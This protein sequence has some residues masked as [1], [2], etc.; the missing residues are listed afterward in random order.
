MVD[1]L[2]LHELES[3]LQKIDLLKSKENFE[4]IILDNGLSNSSEDEVNEFLVVKFMSSEEVDL[5]K[6]YVTHK[7]REDLT[8]LVDAIDSLSELTARIV[9]LY[10]EINRCKSIINSINRTIE[11]V[12]FSLRDYPNIRV[13]TAYSKVKGAYNKYFD[14]FIKDGMDRAKFTEEIDKINRSGIIFRSLKKPQLKQL[15]KGLDEHIRSSEIDID[16]LYTRYTN[17]RD[18]YGVYLRDV[19]MNLLDKNI[20]LFEAGLLSLVSLYHEDI[21]F[22]TSDDGI[23]V[24]DE[25]K[26]NEVTSKYISDK[27]FEYFQKLDKT[28]FDE[29]IFIECFREFLLHFYVREIEKINIEINE[30]FNEIR[31][32]FI[33]QRELT[34]LMS[35]CQESIII[36][37]TEF[38][39]DSQDTM[40]LI[41]RNVGTK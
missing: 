16:K 23:I 34:G 18:E 5:Y 13:S 39:A 11:K 40:S 26:S 19:M 29:K 3:I 25:S 22:T 41:Y 21:K 8:T 36:P 6:R 7:R 20:I 17:S 10:D 15:R 24:F 35:K 27:A 12:D 28:E 37:Q 30:K 9:S 14:A 33:S 31:S 2:M 32:L 38:D 1:E 4:Q